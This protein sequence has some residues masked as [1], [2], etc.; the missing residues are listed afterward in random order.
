ML[1]NRPF[2]T[3]VT[4]TLNS[5]T[6]IQ[7]NLESVENQTY[8]NYEHIFVDGGSKDDTKR[9]LKVYGNKF[10]DRVKIINYLKKG[11]ST[12]FN[13]GVE[14]ASGKYIF[15]L[16]SDDYLYD[17][18]V[19]QDTYNFLSSHGEL[20]WV[21]GKINVVEED[22]KTVGVFPLRKIFQLA[23]RYLLKFINYIPHQSVFIKK[24]IF[25]KFGNFDPKLK[26][27]MDTDLFLRLSKKTNWVFF[28]RIISNYVL[29]NDSLSSSYKN[30][31]EGLV[32]LEEVQDRYLSKT[33]LILAKI[34]NR[35]I[36]VYNK[37]Y[38]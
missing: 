19:F 26:L 31:K 8:K 30:K 18:K 17:N 9:T 6:F 27:N 16:N 38:R 2:F 33:E 32:S 22:G 14:K 21:Y 10:G 35:L 34:V 4:C 23:N 25:Y 3:I 11:V 7:R 20:D 37:T 1:K 29:R 5:S 24:N 28:D 15:F 36:A 13:K 12:A